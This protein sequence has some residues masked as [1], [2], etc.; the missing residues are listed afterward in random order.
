M[1][2]APNAVGARQLQ[3]FRHIFTESSQMIESTF[4]GFI[5]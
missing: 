2:T 4:G 3:A 5:A 1:K